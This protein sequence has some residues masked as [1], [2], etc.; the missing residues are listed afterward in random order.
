MS[1]SSPS[2]QLSFD[3]PCDYIEEAVLDVL[4]ASPSKLTR[5]WSDDSYGN[6]VQSSSFDGILDL[7]K[8]NDSNDSCF[9]LL[10][11]SKKDKDIVTVGSTS[12]NFEHDDDVIVVTGNQEEDKNAS[13]TQVLQGNVETA[14]CSSSTVPDSSKE[15]CLPKDKTVLEI[16]TRNPSSV[17]VGPIDGIACASSD[18]SVEFPETVQKNSGGDNVGKSGEKSVK[19]VEKRK[20]QISWAKGLTLSHVIMSPDKKNIVS[21]GGIATNDLYLATLTTFA[22]RIGCVIKNTVARKKETVIKCIHN[23]I[24]TSDY[25]SSIHANTPLVKKSSNK[26][27]KPKVLT[28][29]GSLYRL[30]NV[31]TS[32]KGKELFLLSKKQ[33]S[34]HDLDTKSHHSKVYADLLDLYLNEDDIDELHDPEG[35]IEVYNVSKFEPCLYDRFNNGDELKTVVD[36]L[37]AHYKE[38]RNNKTK[39]GEHK[40]FSAFIHGKIW[41]L[42]F[43]QRLVELGDTDIMSCA[44]VELDVDVKMTSDSQLDFSSASLLTRKRKAS[45]SKV[46]SQK[47]FFTDPDV[48]RLAK[49]AQT[50]FRERNETVTKIT[51]NTRLSELGGLIYEVVEDIEQVE[52]EVRIVKEQ[53]RALEAAS[54]CGTAE[55]KEDADGKVKLARL[56]RKWKFLKKNKELLELEYESLHKALG[57]GQQ[58][59]TGEESDSDDSFDKI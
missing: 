17:P 32:P 15:N 49:E 55:R 10:S 48:V 5:V 7:N 54:T 53:K 27:T 6:I 46:V 2:K 30:V 58:K 14:F 12:S 28:K 41:L 29:D 1:I 13:D 9:L 56:K 26:K 40:P 11:P 50:S 59:R 51:Q 4:I 21:I 43:H 24:V 31:L 33:L 57:H 44:Y 23:H 35:N 8:S 37:C 45:P 42:Y 20:A 18:S 25:R 22:R 36:Y 52:V 39:S 19:A 47:S 38:V 34:K 3:E 16:S